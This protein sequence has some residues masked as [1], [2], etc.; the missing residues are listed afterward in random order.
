MAEI[1]EK[2]LEDYLFALKTGKNPLEIY[3]K[4]FRQVNLDGYGIIDL[5]YVEIE[6]SYSPNKHEQ[7]PD[8]TITIVELK[9]GLIDFTALGQL[10]RYKRGVERFLSIREKQR[11]ST[12]EN[13]KVKG[14]LI[15]K[16]Y[17]SGDIC[18]AIDQIKWVKCW[19]FDFNLKNGISFEESSGWINTDENF[20]SL[21]RLKE[22]FFPKYI[23]SFKKAR[24][25]DWSKIL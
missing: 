5:L 11:W 21:E 20:K 18:F 3:G 25:E 10:C 17:A 15:G 8:V 19:H 24:K 7:Y 16:D 4:C 13:I 2:E 14:I 22:S 9:K 1:S 12:Y 6:P 23:R